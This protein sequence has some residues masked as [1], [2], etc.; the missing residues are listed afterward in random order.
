MGAGPQF[1]AFRAE[2]GLLHQQGGRT[3]IN[4]RVG[5]SVLRLITKIFNHFEPAGSDPCRESGF[6]H[7]P[8]QQWA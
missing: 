7:L 4:E 5:V 2:F 3:K 8:A 1:A 6:E